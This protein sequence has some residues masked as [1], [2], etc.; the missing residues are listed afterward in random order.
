MFEPGI[1]DLAGARCSESGWT[2]FSGMDE[3]CLAALFGSPA[4]IGSTLNLM[5]GAY[6]APVAAMKKGMYCGGA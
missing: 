3:Q 2:I 1:A 5:P 4:N 6:K